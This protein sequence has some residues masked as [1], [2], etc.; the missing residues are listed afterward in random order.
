MLGEHTDALLQEL[1]YRAD[2]IV[3]MHDEGLIGAHGLGA[4]IADE[5]ANA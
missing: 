2:E 5:P 4:P 3:A 1:G